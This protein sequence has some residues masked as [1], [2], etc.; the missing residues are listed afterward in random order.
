MAALSPSRWLGRLIAPLRERLAARAIAWSRRRQG[1]DRFPVQIERR[2]VYILPTRAGLGFGVL[3]LG[4]T[5]A[6]LNYANSV[7]LLA[8]F[9]LGGFVL[10]AMNLCHRNLLG[11]RVDSLVV[12]PVFAGSQARLVLWLH[13]DADQARHSFTA[14]AGTAQSEAGTLPPRQSQ[15]LELPISAV[16]RGRQALPRIGLSTEFP[17]G[18]FR[19]WTWLHVDETLLVYPAPRGI[20]TPPV[21]GSDVETG[22][23]ALAGGGD[24]WSGLRPFRDGDS[25]RQVAWKAYARGAP[26]LVKEYTG[27]GARSLLFDYASLDGLAT[28]AR[29]EQ[30]ARWVVDAEASGARYGLRLPQ[31]H[32][33][34]ARGAAHQHRCLEA[35]ALHG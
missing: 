25:P 27:R 17:F 12:E 31:R 23:L 14:S 34:E 28:E 9:A 8:A 2:R 1:V 13:N 26:L 24:E 7:A 15:R 11:L 4:M 3:L 6:G 10:V 30:L 18:L 22:Q 32:I 29:L 20:R 35:L 16:R 21:T 33:A 19:A 5:L